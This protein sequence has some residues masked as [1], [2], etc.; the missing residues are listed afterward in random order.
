MGQQKEPGDTIGEH[1]F[2][3]YACGFFGYCTKNLPRPNVF[4]VAGMREKTKWQHYRNGTISF[5][6]L[7]DHLMNIHGNMKDIMI[8]FAQKHYCLKE[9]NGSYSIKYV[10]PALCPSDPALDYKNLEGVQN[11]NDASAAFAR[12]AA[13]TPEERNRTR[14]NL[15]KYCG[16]D[17]LAMVK[18]WEKLKEAAGSDG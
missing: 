18:V 12:M 9:M 7:R 15:L 3:P 16:L 6:D 10:L 13:M 1:C 14:E 11:G 17:T 4:D 2:H 8:P 5:P